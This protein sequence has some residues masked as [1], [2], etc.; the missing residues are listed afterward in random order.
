M[1]KINYLIH[2]PGNDGRV[3]PAIATASTAWLM[4]LL[5]VIIVCVLSVVP[6]SA[7]AAITHV[8]AGASSTRNNCGNITPTIPAGSIDDVLVA[9]VNARETARP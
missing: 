6:T 4:A 9:V 2:D 5:M 3:P 7:V 1:F 8:G